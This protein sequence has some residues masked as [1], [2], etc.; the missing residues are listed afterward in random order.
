MK[1][2]LIA[3]YVAVGMAALGA[4]DSC[5][6]DSTT[7]PGSNGCANENCGLGC[8]DPYGYVAHW[9]CKSST[10]GTSCCICSWDTFVCDCKFGQGTGD[11]ATQITGPGTCP[12]S[13][14]NL[15]VSI[16]E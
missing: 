15:C 1:L 3:V 7:F 11:V 8:G 12:A 10:G 14:G 13:N 5:V 4:T 16:G 6:W 9:A 2:K